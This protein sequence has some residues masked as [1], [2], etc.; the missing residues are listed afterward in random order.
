MEMCWTSVERVLR[1]WK[2]RFEELMNGQNEKKREGWTKQ[3]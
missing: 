1:Q 3:K 2:E